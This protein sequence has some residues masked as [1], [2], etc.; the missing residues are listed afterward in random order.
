[1]FDIDPSLTFLDLDGVQLSL[2]FESINQPHV[3]VPQ[4][5]AQAALGYIVG[6]LDPRGAQAL[7][8]Y[9]WLSRS[10]EAVIY[11]F[12]DRELLAREW[13]PMRERALEFCESMGFMMEELALPGVD[14]EARAQLLE[15]LAPFQRE[16]ALRSLEGSASLVQAPTGPS[17]NAN[18]EASGPPGLL[19]EPLEVLELIDDGPALSAAETAKLARL[20]VSF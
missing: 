8:V 17:M 4:R 6:L 14:S 2:L 3:A 13:D 15:S 5:E 7:Y 16:P 19:L 18:Y 1:M 11:R 12:Q 9:L 20:L 10:R